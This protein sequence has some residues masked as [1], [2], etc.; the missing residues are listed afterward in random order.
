MEISQI[1][2]IANNRYRNGQNLECWGRFVI[3]S[4]RDILLFYIY[5]SQMNISQIKYTVD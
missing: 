1:L 3:L 5:I 4:I 2:Y